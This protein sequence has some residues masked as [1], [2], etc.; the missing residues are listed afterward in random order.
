MYGRLAI[1]FSIMYKPPGLGVVSSVTCG[2]CMDMCIFYMT[3]QTYIN[4]YW[5]CKMYKTKYRKSKCIYIYIYIIIDHA[6][7]RRQNIESLGHLQVFALHTR[8]CVFVDLIVEFSRKHFCGMFLPVFWLVALISLTTTNY[9]PDWEF[10]GPKR[11]HQNLRRL[12]SVRLSS[13]G[14]D[15]GEANHG[16]IWRSHP[17]TSPGD[18]SG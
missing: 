16:K 4:L 13:I 18:F 9:T 3:V 12:A 8:G 1:Y 14:V 2:L 17:R 10:F 11:R 15:L 5:A 7:C 6:K